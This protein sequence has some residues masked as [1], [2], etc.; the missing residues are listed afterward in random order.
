M[1][2]SFEII[3]EKIEKHRY[4]NKFDALIMGYI[5]YLNQE[6][7][8][9]VL[10]LDTFLSKYFQSYNDELFFKVLFA[11]FENG[12]GAGNDMANEKNFLK[13]P[14]NTFFDQG[15]T[16]LQKAQLVHQAFKET[17]ALFPEEEKPNN[18]AILQFGIVLWSKDVFEKMQSAR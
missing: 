1:K 2:T 8:D 11:L 5:D 16:P 18:R 10:L 3:G 6:G 15:S 14:N 4:L 9:E 12:I 7:Q 17:Q 13:F